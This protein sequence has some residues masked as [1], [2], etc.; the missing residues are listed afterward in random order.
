MQISRE[1]CF[2]ELAQAAT[3]WH[4]L[5]FFP[6]PQGQGSL[7]PTFAAARV[8]LG[9]STGAAPAWNC[10]CC[11]WRRCLRSISSGENWDS[12]RGIGGADGFSSG[13]AGGGAF[14]GGSP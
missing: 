9:G 3:P 6:E 8:G 12:P 2:L 1:S 13:T 4:F 5:Y 11:C 14:C 7:R 10:I